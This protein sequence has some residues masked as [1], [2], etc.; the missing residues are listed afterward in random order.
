MTE[1]RIQ[2]YAGH[3]SSP[4]MLRAC[5]LILDTFRR[6]PEPSAE[7]Y[8]QLLSLILG[9]VV[10][11]QITW[12]CTERRDMAIGELFDKLQRDLLQLSSPD[13]GVAGH[14]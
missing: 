5:D 4:E 14:G 2:L 8:F 3:A 13:V 12:D 10:G 6:L 1:Q 9:N 11:G 7:K